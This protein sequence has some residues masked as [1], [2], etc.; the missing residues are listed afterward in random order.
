MRQP[1]T[2]AAILPWPIRSPPTWSG[3][4]ATSGPRKVPST[5]ETYGKA[6]EQLGAFLADK[7]MP[8]TSPAI[9]REHVEAF[10]V[11]LQDRGSGRRPWRN[12][13]GRSSSSSNGSTTRARSA[14]H[15]ME[16]MRPPA[17]PEEPP[18]SSARTSSGALLAVVAGHEFDERR[19]AAILRLLVDT[20]MDEASFPG[21]GSR[22]S[23][24]DSTTARRRQG[25]AAG[26]CR[27]AR[28]GT[29]DRPLPPGPGRHPDADARV[30]VARPQG[31]AHRHRRP[32]D[33]PAPGR[34]G[35]I[36]SD[37]TS[38]GTR[39]PTWLARRCRR[40]TS[41][42]SPDGGAARCSPAT[43]ASAADERAR[44]AYR[45]SRPARDDRPAP[46]TEAQFLADEVVRLDQARPDLP[47]DRALDR[48]RGLRE[49]M[50]TLD[51]SGLP[52]KTPWLGREGEP[53]PIAAALGTPPAARPANRRG[54][55]RPGEAAL[56]S[57]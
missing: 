26:A 25:P 46:L 4:S 41:C 36:T 23:T 15:P 6:I 24:C 13:T 50:R 3:S 14:S 44:E 47:T 16:R 38:S 8:R 27:S 28:D 12:G 7:G 49:A 43:G 51:R 56:A 21:S 45:R 57:A 2:Q 20:G 33:G 22:T 35:G 37:P 52:S 11:D 17:V 9:R 48:P 39:S 34:A 54:R 10:L 1:T 40:A 42:A 31:P 19:D 53:V 55:S 5:I 32:A 18:R 30:A 29:G